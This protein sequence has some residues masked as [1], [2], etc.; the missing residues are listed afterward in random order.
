MADR[1]IRVRIPVET[2]DGVNKIIERINKEMPGA[3]ATISTVTRYALQDYVK[4]Y[5]QTENKGEV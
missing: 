3:E 2:A 5:S 1:Q 4:R